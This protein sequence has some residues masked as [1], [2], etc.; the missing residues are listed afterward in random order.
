MNIS[1]IIDELSDSFGIQLEINIVKFPDRDEILVRP[2]DFVDRKGFVIISQVRWLTLNSFIQFE[3]FSGDIFRSIHN[4]QKEK[5]GVLVNNLNKLLEKRPI[6]NITVKVDNHITFEV[7]EN[8]D[9]T[10]LSI[11]VEKLTMNVDLMDKED[12]V[13]GQQK[14]LLGLILIL[15]EFE[16]NNRSETE[17]IE[18]MPEGSKTKIEVNKYERSKINRQACINFHGYNCKI[19]G[20]NFEKKYGVLGKNYIHV[21]HIKP[22]SEL[23]E[24]YIINPIED[25]IPVCPNCHNMIHRYNPAVDIKEIINLLNNE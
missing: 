12:Y 25:L 14:L 24:N 11:S 4:N 2:S 9:I 3:D 22:V 5:I 7:K 8:V 21:H 15:F 18:G 16:E 23:T 6:N 19:C 17:I 10:K 13:I 20:F 1:K